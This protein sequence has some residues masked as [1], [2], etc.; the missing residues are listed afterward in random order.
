MKVP[1]LGMARRVLIGLIRIY[2]WTVSP[3]LGP[4]C[5]FFPTCSHYGI[6]AIEKHGCVHGGWLTTRRLVRCH[7]FHAGGFDPVPPPAHERSSRP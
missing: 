7:P 3:W 6:E 5:R 2:Q 4:R 1:A